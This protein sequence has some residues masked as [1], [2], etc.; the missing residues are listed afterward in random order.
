MKAANFA[1]EELE[2]Y[3]T[4]DKTIFFQYR[5]VYVLCYSRNAGYYFQEREILYKRTGPP[6][7]K[8]CRFHAFNSDGAN[9]LIGRE[10]FIQPATV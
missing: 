6:Y 1:I 2:E 10:F 9:K 5:K 3:Y 8:K 7:T 4:S